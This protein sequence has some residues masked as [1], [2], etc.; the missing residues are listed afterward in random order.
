M[1]N[2]AVR[3]LGFLAV[4][5]LAL[6]VSSGIS[7]GAR[8][9]AIEYE[10]QYDPD[11]YFLVPNETV[12][13]DIYL[14]AGTG[15]QLLSFGVFYEDFLTYDPVASAALS[16]KGPGPSGAQPSY[17][18]YSPP[19][20]KGAATVLYPQHTPAFATWPNPPPGMGQVNIDYAEASFSPAEA[21]GTNIWIASLVFHANGFGP[22]ADSVIQLG[23]SYDAGHVIYANDHEIQFVDVPITLLNPLPEPVTGLLLF[24]GVVVAGLCGVRQ[25][26]RRE[27]RRRLT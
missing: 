11:P 24:V 16:P 10:I 14:D 23:F 25:S 21:S 27:P 26:R 3:L 17:I 18:L 8:A 9:F 1:P 2:H 12:Q 4:L 15:L 22:Q 5:G 20:G 6:G 13:V 19:S 7:S